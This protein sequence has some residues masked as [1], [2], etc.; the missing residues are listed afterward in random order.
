MLGQHQ[1]PGSV[2]IADVIYLTASREPFQGKF[3]DRL[4][5]HVACLVADACFL[6]EQNLVDERSNTLEQLHADGVCRDCLGCGQRDATA[7]DPEPPEERL[8][9]WREKVVTPG[10]GVAHRLL[11]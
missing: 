1:I 9:R 10:N 5:H 6:A 4:Q 7:E 3:A 2:A 11:A 8:F